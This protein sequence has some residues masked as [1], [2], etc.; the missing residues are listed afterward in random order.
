MMNPRRIIILAIVALVVVTS[1]VLFANRTTHTSSDGELLYP[2]LQAQA[3]STTAIRIYTA[4]DTR[5]LEIV[6][7]GADWTLTERH[8][9]PVAAVKARNLVRALAG[10]KLV[11]EKTS[12]A[13]KYSALS[14]ADVSNEDAEGVRIELEGPASAVNLIV[15]KDGPG[16]RSSYVRRVGDATSWLV[17]EQLSASPEPR[18]WLRKEIVNISADRVQ[19]ATVETHGQQPY[20]ASKDSRAAADFAVEPLPRGKELTSSSAANNIATALLSLSLDDVRPKSEFENDKP[21]AQATFKTFDGLVVE[22]D[23]FERDDK[24]YI[25]LTASFDTELA[26]RFEVKTADDESAADVAEDANAATNNVEQEAQELQ[27]KTANWG[28]EIPGYKYD[29]IF[30]RLG[31]MLK[32]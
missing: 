20:T 8:D 13:S 1:A 2:E 15:G 25:T 11:E 19:A 27:A 7:D 16:G 18:D 3:E 23:G 31:E 9:H 17:S 12:D 30:R 10:A 32:K 5:A 6:R 22:L 21:S 4:G 28:Y 14:V 24:H 29:A 26:A